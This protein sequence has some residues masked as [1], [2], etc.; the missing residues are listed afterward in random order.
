MNTQHSQKHH[1]RAQRGEIP[2][3]FEQQFAHESDD[4]VMVLLRHH[5]AQIRTAA[6]TLLGARV[7]HAA[8]VPLCEGLSAETAL[9]ARIA[10][11]EALVEIGE[12]AISAL[13][14]RIGTIGHNRHQ[15]LPTT[16]FKKWNYPLPR[17]LAVRTL[18][19]L[20]P[21]VLPSLIAV[22]HT[23]SESHV[24]S[25]VIDAIGFVTYYSG[26]C[27]AFEACQQA[28]V[29]YAHHDVILWKCIR[30]FQAFPTEETVAVLREVLLTSACPQHRWEA[31]RSLGQI[32]RHGAKQVL[33]TARN[34]PH[35]LVSEMV[36]R[37]LQHIRP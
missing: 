3:G 28:W 24:I 25:E 15:S 8:I 7:C 18:V 13:L 17:D 12:P 34:D 31:A 16:L 4:H 10:M 30:A 23:T 26:D 2:S 32:R 21:V 6:A 14:A 27:Q 29:T 19:K 11:S 9:Y 35:P 20:G 1:A 36:R 33:Q 5:D 22:L 37:S